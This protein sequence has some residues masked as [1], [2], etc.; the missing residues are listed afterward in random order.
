MTYQFTRRNLGSWQP[1]LSFT[2]LAI[3]CCITVNL[4]AQTPT[5]DDFDPD[6]DDTIYSIAAQS[7]GKI[8]TGGRFSSVG[9]EQQNQIA[10]LNSDGSLETGFSSEPDDRVTALHLQTDGKILI[11]GW[12]MSL[13]QETRWGI[14]LLENSG[15]VDTNFIAGN[16]E[17]PGVPGLVSA[18]AMQSTGHFVVGGLFPNTG[19]LERFQNG[20]AFDTN[21]NIAAQ[22]IYTNGGGPSAYVSTVAIQP[23]DKILIGGFFTTLGGQSHDYLGRLNADG[24]LDTNFNAIAN[25]VV[26][27]IAVQSDGKI[28]LGGSFTSVGGQTRNRIARI[29]ADGTLDV[30]FDPGSGGVVNSIALQTDGKILVGGNFTT[31]GGQPRNRIARLDLNGTLDESFNPGAG[32]QVYAVAVQPDGKILIG[33][34][35]TSLAGQ[36]RNRIGRLN[37]TSPAT[38]SLSCS[39]SN[40][41]WLRTGSSPEVWRTTFEYSPDGIAWAALGAG[42]RITNGWQLTDF[43]LPSAG[44]IRAR[45]FVVGGY[46]NASSWFAES[47]LLLSGPTNVP[48]NILVNDGQFGLSTNRFGFNING[49]TGQTIV[50]E[51]SAD[52]LTWLP[53]ATNAL[54]NVPHYFSEPY[55][56]QGSGRFYRLRQTNFE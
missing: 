46:Q 44:I 22:I 35:F 25:G 14:G 27:A 54:L 20:G 4:F 45:G 11:G 2:P 36:S 17:A 9:G 28:L 19:N 38:Q 10:R 7:D 42:V 29:N 3:A 51:A 33:G 52:L 15:G 6:V 21:F 5:A 31:F 32:G 18:L 39:S 24:S 55:T 37:N 48:P 16:S 13:N 30:G 47:T 26:N 12:F 56:N 23:D 50:V 34:S 40:I 1:C 41:T 43:T 53:V 8:L 49:N